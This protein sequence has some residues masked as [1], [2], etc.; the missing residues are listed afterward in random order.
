MKIGTHDGTFHCD[1]ALACFM[2]RLLHTDAEIVRTRKPEILEKCDIVVDVGAVYDADKGRFDH[3][4]RSF[5]GTFDAQHKVKLSSAGLIYKHFGKQ[6]I[7]RVTQLADEAVDIIYQRV[8]DGFIQAIDGIDN[9]V[10]MYSTALKPAYTINTDLS[11]RVGNL[12]PSWNEADVDL[13]SRFKQAM[14]LT[15]KE[16]LDAVQFVA[17]SWIPARD[18][19]K[20]ALASRS[21]YSSTGEIVVMK[22]YTIWKTHLLLLE[23]ELKI[24]P[25]VKF[26]LYADQS[27]QW[28]VQA[29]PERDDSFASRVPLLPAWQGV[30]DDELSK[31]SGIPDCV[32][33]HATGFIGGNKTFEGALEMAKRSL[34]GADKKPKSTASG[35][36][37][38]PAAQQDTQAASGS[39]K[40]PGPNAV[41]VVFV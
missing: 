27:G 3:H 17:K 37:K 6:V 20:R 28:R 18:I 4:Q 1:E 36:D 32:F 16:F 9:G 11:S 21:E 19:V 41:E 39:N 8:Y 35:N 22:E 2:L 24:S 25:G 13:D 12:N 33:V 29:V 15:G 31:L 40:S 14:E 10:S 38:S 30:R 5:T 23:E 26:V 7:S 34:A